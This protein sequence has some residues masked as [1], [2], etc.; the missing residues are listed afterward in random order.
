V[1]TAQT[2][3]NTAMA[4]QAQ[5]AKQ[6]QQN[7]AQAQS[8]LA[9]AQAQLS[10]DQTKLAAAVT[11]A[12]NQVKQAQAGLATAQI[13]VSQAEAKATATVQGAQAQANQA[14]GSLKSAQANYQQTVAPPTQ[15]DLDAAKAQVANA[16]AAVESAQ[17]NLS[18]ATLTSPIDGTIAAVNGAVGQWIS[19]G[20]TSALSGSTASTS[21]LFTLV[22]MDNLQVIAQVNEADIGK[23]KVGDPVNFTVSAYPNEAFSGKVL[24]IQPVGTTVQNVVN[25]NVTCSIQ[26]SKSSTLYPGMTAA[27]TIISAEK[28]NVVLVPNSALTFAQAAFR[29]GLVQGAGGQARQS[30]TRGQPTGQASGARPTGQ[31][32]LG[33]GGN[34]TPQGGASSSQGSNADQA[35][36]ANRGLALTLKNGELVPIRL[37]LGITDGTNTEV[38]SGLQDG[39]SIVIGESGASSV[40]TNRTGSTP[41]PAGRAP[42]GGGF[43]G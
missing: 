23:V 43:G 21:A 32:G 31:A 40:S 1:A 19:G 27:A 34:A 24:E 10:S 37:T 7:I 9:A 4:Q 33:R 25:Y 42:F 16:Q 15:A 20:D 29:D 14:S 28:D 8:V 35:A 26:S 30:R 41:R 6:D 5:G 39:E 12:Q 18:S 2:A 13:G 11:S 36:S 17:R 22:T 38:V 3:L